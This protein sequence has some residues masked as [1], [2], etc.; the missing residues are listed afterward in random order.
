MIKILAELRFEPGSHDPDANALT[1]ILQA[2]TNDIK[3]RV[4]VSAALCGNKSCQTYRVCQG[5]WPLWIRKL[6]QICKWNTFLYLS[7]LG[8]SC[9][10]CS[11]VLVPLFFWVINSWIVFAKPKKLKK[12]GVQYFCLWRSGSLAHPVCSIYVYGKGGHMKSNL[13][14]KF[15]PI[16]CNMFWNVILFILFYS[17]DVCKSCYSK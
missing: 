16:T 17:T 6:L 3:V 5:S 1:T 13:V 8:A 4:R 9:P 14:C 15:P 7:Y 10:R 11:F 12:L 2:F